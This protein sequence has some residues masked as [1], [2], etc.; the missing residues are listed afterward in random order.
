MQ[1]MLLSQLQ[2]N[3][4]KKAGIQSNLKQSD[5]HQKGQS[6]FQCCELCHV[7]TV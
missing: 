6:S 1:K 3:L 4:V 7:W 5:L 2:L